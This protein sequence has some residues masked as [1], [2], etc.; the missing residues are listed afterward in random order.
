MCRYPL[1]EDQPGQLGRVAVSAKAADKEGEQDAQAYVASLPQ[2]PM[3]E[4][5]APVLKS[6]STVVEAVVARGPQLRKSAVASRGPR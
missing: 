3:A 2:Q 4:A 6:G 5:S 1:A